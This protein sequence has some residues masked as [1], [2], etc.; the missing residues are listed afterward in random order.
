M[1][2]Q[3]GYEV[4][5]IAVHDKTV[6]EDNVKIVGIP[7]PRGRFGRMTGT[8]WNIFLAALRE[9]ADIYHIHDAELLPWGQV[10]RLLGKR[11][12]F[13]MHENL[14]EDIRT[15]AWLPP[16]IASAVGWIFKCF[17]PCLLANMPII[18]A[19]NSYVKYYPYVKR[20]VV[21]LNMP[22]LDRLLQV[23]EPK[24]A[25]FTLG[26][27]GSVA[28]SRGSLN[29]LRA[30]RILK[31]RGYKIAYE[32]VGPV[33]EAHRREIL[34]LASE[35]ELGEVRLH[36]YLRP[37][38]G[39]RLMARSHLGLAV[40]LPKPNYFE[41]Y[42]TKLFEYMALGLPVV[43][44]DF[45]LYREVV[46]T[47]DCGLYVNPENPVALADAIERL[48]TNPSCASKYGENGR[49]SVQ[50]QYN[51]KTESSKLLKFYEDMLRS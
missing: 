47:A 5:L 51:W 29:T 33:S 45:P 10:L 20:S 7:K 26:Y 40:L 9:R 50:K 8:A 32:C 44:S 28:E 11:V 12:I 41:S 17:A 22:I 2:A 3:S 35:C 48:I 13:D 38:E 36:G 37:E 27:F 19:E 21:L 49:R 46:S 4:S 6:L 14:V 16:A 23:S 18:F 42:P 31:E 25:E 24:N 34:N 15:K 30:M 1:L 39:W 43:V